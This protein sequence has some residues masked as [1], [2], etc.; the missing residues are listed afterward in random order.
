MINLY[1]IRGINRYD[2]PYFTNK[3]A[4]ANYFNSSVK[5]ASVDAWY[6]PHYSNTIRLTSEEL[7][8]NLQINYVG[9]IYNNKEYFYFIDD[10]TYVNED[11]IEIE[12]SMDDIQTYMFDIDF[13]HSQ[14]S[15][16]LIN[17]WKGDYIN[18]EY[19]REDISQGT[20]SLKSYTEIPYKNPMLIIQST[21]SYDSSQNVSSTFNMQGTYLSDGIYYYIQPYILYNADSTQL[22][23][24]K[25]N[26]GNYSSSFFISNQT[27]AIKDQA[28]IQSA[29]ISMYN[30]IDVTIEPNGP[31][32]S[33]VY[34]FKDS[35][36]AIREKTYVQVKNFHISISPSFY[37]FNFYKNTEINTRFSINL[38]PQLLDENYMHFNWGERLGATTFPLS[39][40]TDITLYMYGIVDYLTGNRTYKI[41]DGG[42]EDKYQ[43]SITN[44]TQENILLVNDAFKEYLA[45]Y[46]GTLMMG[47]ARTGVNLALSSIAKPVA[48]TIEYTPVRHKISAKSK[49]AMTKYKQDMFNYNTGRYLEGAET[50][51][52]GEILNTIFKPD[53]TKQGNAITS[54]IIS[55][56]L[57]RY[58]S[59]EQVTDIEDVAKIIEGYGYKVHENYNNENL[60][61]VLNTRYY[62][63]VI[64]C[65]DIEISL[66]LINDDNTI[67]RIIERFT[68]GLRLWNIDKGAIAQYLFV[69]DNVE[70]EYI[71]S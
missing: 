39:K 64:Q 41:T 67:T 1:Y 63:N 13:I 16:R 26:D 59:V 38:C 14:V 42:T 34:S 36:K 66:N 37:K 24:C 9:L 50:L 54:D 51:G 8:F 47:M 21:K 32:Q 33:K 69:Y 19:L 58:Y 46:K 11:T 7:N 43:T 44:M 5:K 23:Q 40:M 71:E 12:I 49:R 68:N 3:E 30:D 25:D 27:Y 17:R 61:N 55:N 65:D 18:R 2:T 22:Y 6:P 4:Q 52:T 60:F 70:K 10:I 31:N 28:D 35:C 57:K 29:Y 15:R 45:N 56:A 20:M 62:Y 53:T 48:P